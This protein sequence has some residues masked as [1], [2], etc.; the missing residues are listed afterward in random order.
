MAT[1]P[2]LTPEQR[3]LLD[4]LRLARAAYCRARN[5]WREA[6]DAWMKALDACRKAGLDPTIYPEQASK[7]SPVVTDSP[8]MGTIDW[9]KA[10]QNCKSLTTIPHIYM[11]PDTRA[12]IDDLLMELAA[13]PVQPS[14]FNRLQT[15]LGELWPHSQAKA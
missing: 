6:D 8:A 7:D 12:Q 13:T 10:F 14:L 3:Q 1:L 11:S 4:Q 9:T 5:T 2:P 15:L